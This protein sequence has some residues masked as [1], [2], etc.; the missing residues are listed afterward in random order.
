M[1]SIFSN[2]PILLLL[3]SEELAQKCQL[4][5][6][7]KFLVSLSCSLESQDVQK[8]KF[9][10]EDIVL[11]GIQ[12]G[13]SSALL[14]FTELEKHGV[15]GPQDLEYLRTI[16]VNIPRRDLVAKLDKFV[17]TDIGQASKGM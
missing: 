2:I 16:L 9:L 13:I 3:P 10:T 4:S 6:Y 17:T 8:M 14:L 1:F 11:P 12:E 7:R 5:N 15:L